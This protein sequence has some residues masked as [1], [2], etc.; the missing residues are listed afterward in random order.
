M[1]SEIVRL[2]GKLTV[3]NEIIYEK[4]FDGLRNYSLPQQETLTF[5]ADFEIPKD[6][7]PSPARSIPK[8]IPGTIG[9]S[10]TNWNW[11]ITRITGKDT[12][13]EWRHKRISFLP[14]VVL[15]YSFCLCR[16][17]ALVTTLRLEKAMAPAA[18]IGCNCRKKPGAQ[19]KGART[20]AAIGISSVL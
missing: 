2:A 8:P 19:A 9:Y 5:D 17:R 1:R 16:R 4:W 12:S 11:K 7:P 13:F 14:A 18:K 10:A 20:P 15:G 3:N 6:I